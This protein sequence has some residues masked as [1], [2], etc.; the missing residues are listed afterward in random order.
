MKGEL[1]LESL[2][3]EQTLVERIRD[4]LLDRRSGLAFVGRRYPVEVGGRSD[5]FL[6]LLFYHLHLHCYVAID[7]RLTEFQPEFGSV[8]NLY[9]ATVDEQL[10]PPLDPPSIGILICQG[11][12]ATTIHYILRDYEQPLGISG[13]QV[14]TELPSEL[15]ESLPS[16]AEWESILNAPAHPAFAKV[17][18]VRLYDLDAWNQLR[19]STL[20]RYM[21]QVA[22]DLTSATGFDPAW[23]ESRGTA[24]IVR[25]FSLQR[26]N[27]AAYGDDLSVTTW[28]SN[29]Q[30]V[31]LN[32]DFEVRQAEGSAIAVGRAE[33]VYIDRYTR[34]PQPL[35]PNILAS[36]PA[37]DPSTLWNPLQPLVA[38]EHC[39]MHVLGQSVHCFDAEALGVTS[40]AVYPI[41][42]EE[43]ARLALMSWGYPVELPHPGRPTRLLSLRS[44]E[45]QYL[46]PT[47]PGEA[48]T[49]STHHE[50][51][52]LN[53]QQVG[54]AQE[55]NSADGQ[56]RV[57]AKARYDMYANPESLA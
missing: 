24:F 14:T 4:F 43:A 30:R 40:F 47:R 32:L 22:T 16:V 51:E 2:N 50:G 8:L 53:E 9:L 17:F 44:M 45:L 55:I 18:S 49:I 12:S 13:Y 38:R 26:L 57:R 15:R 46:G 48:I 3:R 31:R 19:S 36:W 25:S 1:S 56:L 42:L 28:V 10:R 7:V 20:M 37:G 5:F 39:A 35:N 6:D 33:W 21:E 29:N 27:A 41:W 34:R 11:V 52:D 54:V 23:Y